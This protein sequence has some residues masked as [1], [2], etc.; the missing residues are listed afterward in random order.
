MQPIRAIGVISGTSMDGVDVAAIETDGGDVARPLGGRTYPYEPALQRRLLDLIAAPEIAF[1]DPL[2]TLEAEVTAAHVAA[3]HRFC[4][5]TGMAAREVAL[6]GLHGQTVLH[7]PERRFTRQLLD[8]AQA[9]AALGVDVVT[10]FRKADV[11]AGGQGA[12]FVPL[13][14]RAMTA[15]L[16]QPV[17]VLNLGG[18]ANITWIDGD[19]VIACDTGP[20]SAL[21]DDFMRRRRGVAYDADGALAASGQVDRAVLAALMDNPF[22]ARPAPKSLD[23][24]DFHQRARVVDALSDADGAATLAAFTVEAT[25]AILAHLPR[26]PSRWLVA[27]GGRRNRTLMAGFAARLGV[28]VDPVEAQGWDGDF[29]EAECFAYLAVRSRLGLPLSLPGTTGVP[30]PMPGGEFHAGS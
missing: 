5:E 19:A 30:A 13:Y 20:A 24:N 4:A 18:V 14:H 10:Q 17:M 28:P 11:A 27:G 21:L 15:G 3:V 12:P 26:A 8:G 25:A 22:F 29:T 7:R 23:R 2:A 1:T 6:V 16:P 9:A